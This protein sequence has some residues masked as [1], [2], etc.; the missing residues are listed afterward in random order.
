MI[1]KE[2][3][4]DARSARDVE[5]ITCPSDCVKTTYDI[6]TSTSTIDL[7]A[8]TTYLQMTGETKSKYI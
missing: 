8:V 1:M 5:R 6:V 3:I 7:D 2:K 4:L